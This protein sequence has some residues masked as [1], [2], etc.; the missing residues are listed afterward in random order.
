YKHTAL[1]STFSVNML[2]LVDGQ[3]ESLSLRR[4]IELFIKHR[5]A[6]VRRRTEFDRKRAKARE[7]LLQGYAI[8]LQHIDEVIALIR[9]AADTDVARRELVRRYALSDIQ[10]NAILDMQLRR[11]VRL[12]REQLQR[13]LRETQQL[14]AEL[15][16]VL[17]DER[18]ILEII[19]QETRQIA[20]KFGDERRTE[21]QLGATAEFTDEDL[22]ADQDC[23]V[24]MGSTGYV[25]RVVASEFRTQGRGGKGVKG[26]RGKSGSLAQHFLVANTHDH[27]LFF[28][29][30][31]KIYRLR[32]Y[33]LPEQGRDAQGH[34]II[35]LI[36]IEQ[37]EKVTAIIAIPNFE[38]GEYLVF[39]TRRGEVKRS[40]LTQFVTVRSTGLLAMDLNPGDEL[41]W[42]RLATGDANVMFFTRKGMAIRFP[43]S[44]VR[45]SGR[46]SGGVKGI[47][48]AEDD[49]VMAMD[50]APEE[51]FV[52][53]VTTNGYGKKMAASEFRAQGRGGQG[54]KA[55]NLAEKT[56]LV[57]DARVLT[58][59][60]EEIMLISSDGQVIRCGLGGVRPLSRYAAGVIVMRLESGVQLV[61]ATG[62]TEGRETNGAE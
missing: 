37:G 61:A 3:P 5:Q 9:K 29:N 24:T 15:E 26:F 22:V 58:A 18:R 50:L 57:A 36:P 59:E 21:I 4:A 33:E 12:E 55:I 38:A 56:G 30:R 7:H 53:V 27:L 62:L 41:A 6:V 31:G 49:E 13:E 8:A 46:T 32:A 19:R 28:T 40:A 11:L 43:L 14:I 17:A 42:V 60:N 44:D 2:A 25:K 20:E 45:P 16:Q 10:A 1:Q 39:G 48:L 23:I 35:N 54:V 34:N 47:T 52:L 51:R